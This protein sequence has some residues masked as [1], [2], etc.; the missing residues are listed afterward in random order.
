[1]ITKWKT[2]FFQEIFK[3]M[4]YN[5]KKINFIIKFM[6]HNIIPENVFQP[7]PLPN[8][9]KRDSKAWYY[10]RYIFRDESIEK[11]LSSKIR[12]APL[13][14]ISG[15]SDQS[16]ISNPQYGTSAFGIRIPSGVWLFSSK[17]AT[18][19]G[20]A[21]ADPFNVWQSSVFLSAER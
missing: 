16:I 1:M 8:S 18:I 3:K 21:N 5:R 9:P 20:R 15:S 14:N 7:N 11:R 10:S 4:L 12:I 6:L 2:T 19:R 13:S 17:A